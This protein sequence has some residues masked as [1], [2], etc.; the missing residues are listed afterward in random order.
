MVVTYLPDVPEEPSVACTCL[1]KS[2][3]LVQAVCLDLA[4]W[5]V[6]FDYEAKPLFPSLNLLPFAS[7]GRFACMHE[8]QPAYDAMA[9]SQDALLS[10]PRHRQPLPLKA[11]L[12]MRALGFGARVLGPAQSQGATVKSESAA[13]RHE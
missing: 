3:S 4:S 11:A 6:S 10:T 5:D 2:R 9:P 12:E 8:T 1:H 13:I 7:L